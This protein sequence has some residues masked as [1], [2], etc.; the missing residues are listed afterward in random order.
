MSTGVTQL[1]P[2]V[3]S[4]LSLHAQILLR[5]CTM[6]FIPHEAWKDRFQA[7][8]EWTDLVSCL[9]CGVHLPDALITLPPRL[10]VAGENGCGKVLRPR[11]PAL[12]L[13]GALRV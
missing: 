7:F 2:L 6:C 5:R 12:P 4:I 9:V 1:A 10:Y 13:I 8:S 3:K 11:Y